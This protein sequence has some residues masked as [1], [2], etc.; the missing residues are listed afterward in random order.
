MK[1]CTTPILEWELPFDVSLIAAV[2]VSLGQNDK[3]ILKKTEADCELTE[4]TIRLQLSQEDTKALSGDYSVIKVELTV[5]TTTGSV[6]K[7]TQITR[8]DDCLD[9]EVI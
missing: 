2:R 1:R 3:V 9:D 8:L 7:D 5:K 4:N 6:L